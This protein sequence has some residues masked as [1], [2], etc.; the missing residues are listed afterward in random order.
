M[1]G[2]KPALARDTHA[3]LHVIQARDAVGIGADGKQ[4]ALVATMPDVPPVDVEALAVRVD[5]DGDFVGHAGVENLVPIQR[6]A[7]AGEE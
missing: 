1:L 5:L 2:G 3:I 6:K 7:L 4:H